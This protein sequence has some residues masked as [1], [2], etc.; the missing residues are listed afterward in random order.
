M[1]AFAYT[2]DIL[3]FILLLAFFVANHPRPPETAALVRRLRSWRRKELDELD[4]LQEQQGQDKLSVRLF[5][6]QTLYYL[7][8]L[9]CAFAGTFYS[10]Y[11]FAFHLL[12]IVNNNQ[13]LQG[14]IQAVT[15]NGLSLIWVS[16]LGI[17]IMYLYAVVAFAK[18]RTGFRPDE[19]LMFC[20]NLYQCFITVLRFGLIG[21][22][23]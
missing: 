12:N 16:I 17:V 1:Q 15:T 9:G 10:P 2:L 22:L 5:S 14:V 3:A 19:S 4:D 7:V 13:M 18:F 6:I 8:F 20:G 21:D 11:F 23:F